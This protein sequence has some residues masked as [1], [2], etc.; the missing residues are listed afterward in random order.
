M[1]NDKGFKKWASV[2]VCVCVCV[3]VGGGGGGGGGGGLLLQY[4]I[5]KV[6]I[7]NGN[8]KCRSTSTFNDVHIGWV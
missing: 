8:M 7:Q 6:I 2:C 3:C 1:K 4:L 5:I